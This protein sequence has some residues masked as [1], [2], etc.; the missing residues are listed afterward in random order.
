MSAG[1]GPPLP[2][3]RRRQHPVVTADAA[4]TDA[5]S[6]VIA[7]AFHDMPQSQWLIS[8]ADARRQILPGYFRLLPGIMVPVL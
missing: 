1:E 6:E 5:L 3:R 2:R 7:S 4:D 8:D